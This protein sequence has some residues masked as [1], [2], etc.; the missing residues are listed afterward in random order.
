MENA[1]VAS[2]SKG[3]IYILI[4]DYHKSKECLKSVKILQTHSHNLYLKIT[5]L[6]RRLSG[7]ETVLKQDTLLLYNP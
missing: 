6:A 1:P 5:G 4:Y 2:V 3:V 7:G